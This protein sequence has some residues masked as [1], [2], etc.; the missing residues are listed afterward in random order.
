MAIIGAFTH[1]PKNAPHDSRT[2]LLVDMLG[3]LTTSPYGEFN[4]FPKNFPQ[5]PRTSLLGELL[6]TSLLTPY[7][8]TFLG[9][10]LYELGTLLLTP[11]GKTSVSPY[12]PLLNTGKLRFP[13]PRTKCFISRKSS[14]ISPYYSP[15]FPPSKLLAGIEECGK[16]PD[17]LGEIS[18]FPDFFPITTP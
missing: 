13:F 15:Y 1:F 8:K 14:P 4:H 10:L 3:I 16:L 17:M 9:D 5:N 7:G 6:G 11:Y 2:S 12:S 18:S